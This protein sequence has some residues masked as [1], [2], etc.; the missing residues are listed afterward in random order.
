M[1]SEKFSVSLLPNT[2][3][4]HGNTQLDRRNDFLKITADV[5]DVSEGA[6]QQ[7]EGNDAPRDQGGSP[8][9]RTL[10]QLELDR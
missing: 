5:L 1:P 9:R 2:P 4:I 3:E 8:R 10:M 7:K 6:R